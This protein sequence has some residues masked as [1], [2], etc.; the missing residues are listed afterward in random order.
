MSVISELFELANGQA[1]RPTND[2]ITYPLSER[3]AG[4][5]L[6]VLSAGPYGCYIASMTVALDGKVSVANLSWEANSKDDERPSEAVVDRVIGLSSHGEVIIQVG[7]TIG[8][9]NTAQVPANSPERVFE[10][11]TLALQPETILKG[12]TNIAEYRWGTFHH[13]NGSPMVVGQVKDPD[14]S[15]LE[16]L[17]AGKKAK[18]VRRQSSTLALLA[19]ALSHPAVT[20]GEF[21][22]LVIDHGSLTYFDI[23]P[24]TG[25]WKTVRRKLKQI[26]PAQRLSEADL[27]N[28][29]DKV[30][31][32]IAK[33]FVGEGKKGQKILVVDGGTS[34][35]PSIPA[36]IGDTIEYTLFAL[37]GVQSQGLAIA[38]SAFDGPIT[39]LAKGKF[40]NRNLV[41]HDLFKG[42]VIVREPLPV[43]AKLIPY[44][45]A[46]AAA[47]LILGAVGLTLLS[48]MTVSKADQVAADTTGVKAQAATAQSDLARLTQ[49]ENYARSVAKWLQDYPMLQPL[50]VQMM[51]AAK[52][53][54]LRIKTFS[55]ERDNNGS[56]N[57][58]LMITF[59]SDT[60]EANSFVAEIESAAK[61]A[62]WTLAP[63]GQATTG[64]DVEVTAFLVPNAL[65]GTVA[66]AT[67]SPSTTVK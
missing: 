2:L 29:N 51:E 44:G 24:N 10:L 34:D 41:A 6:G 38:A 22:V 53:K 7:G 50:V 55:I 49:R 60:R 16:N 57:Y 56:S 23:E 33:D 59:T 12:R 4:H 17:F 19:M 48:K 1:F 63:E 25:R 45:F 40:R 26:Q 66:A 13:P 36:I 11:A 3:V 32:T 8:E 64:S 52:G 31:M 5:R 9:L 30:R 14:I 65:D 21:S 54:T 46:A 62:G 61:K 42:K 67:P 28:Q 18:I 20:K 15:G 35:L 39:P 27:Q 37:E 43:K 58:R 47:A